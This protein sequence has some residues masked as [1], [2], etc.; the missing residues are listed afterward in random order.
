MKRFLRKYNETTFYSAYSRGV[1]IDFNTQKLFFFDSNTIKELE[2]KINFSIDDIFIEN[3]NED[4]NIDFCIG[5]LIKK[6]IVFLCEDINF[7][8]A[9]NYTELSYSFIENIEVDLSFR[10]FEINDLIFKIINDFNIKG[11]KFILKDLNQEEIFDFLDFFSYSNL[12]SIECVF[13]YIKNDVTDD[14]L[15]EILSINGIVTRVSISNIPDGLN[16]EIYDCV[17]ICNED[18][19]F[20]KILASFKLFS[21]S[22]NFHTY[23]NKK[24]FI[25]KG[26]EV[27]ISR[28]SEEI[29]HEIFDDF[30]FDK[31]KLEIQNI[32]YWFVKKDETDVCKDCEFRHICVDNRLPHERFQKEW[33]HKSECNFNPYITKWKNEDGYR[34]LA[35]CGIISNENGF[36]IDHEKIAEINR[37][38]WGEE[39]IEN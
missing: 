29:L 15:K 30:N 12:E 4:S 25:G 6:N 34:T 27:K 7:F 33:Y 16:Y 28:N 20:P 3:K 35:E 18:L 21:E 17:T 14:F 37:E 5:E 31:F 11:A 24:I 32:K 39:I 23:F 26:G 1:A 9:L 2:Q 8:P 19:N 10:L 38:L 13:D 36:S 22:Q